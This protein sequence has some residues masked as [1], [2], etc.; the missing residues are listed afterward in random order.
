M[1][2]RG[3]IFGLLMILAIVAVCGC[4]GNNNFNNS[5]T[6]SSGSS[7][8]SSSDSSSSSNAG[9][10]ILNHK[11]VTGDYGNIEVTG[12]AKN[13]GSENMGYASVDVKFY[14]ANGNLLGSGLDNIN[15]LG[16][17]ETWNFKAMYTGDGP[18]EI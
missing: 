8:S 2:N 18:P 3:V 12:Q 1:K 15:N 6:Q 4:T 5:T 14:D 9:L 16:S 11:M 7:N 17:G 13:T 10:Q